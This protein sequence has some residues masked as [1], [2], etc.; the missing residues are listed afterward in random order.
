[1]ILVIIKL[2]ALTFFIVVAFSQFSTDN[3]TPFAPHGF[4][5]VISGASIIF[6][7]FLGFDAV[8]TGAEEARNPRRD[9]PIAII[10]SLAVATIFYV[11]VAVGA[12]G[13]ATPTQLA[14]SEAPLSAALE[15]G[16]GISWAASFLSVGAIVA[17]TSVLLV[18]LYA[19]TRILFAMCRDGLLP[20]GLASVNPRYGTPAKLTLGLG[21]FIAL[22][23]ALIPLAEI[24]KLVNVG[25][26][27]AFIVVN[28]GVIILRRTRPEMPRPYKVPFSP[29]VPLIGTALAVYLM[30]DFGWATWVRFFAWLIVGLLIY[31]FYGYRNSRIRTPHGQYGILPAEPA[32]PLHRHN[33]PE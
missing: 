20:E 5:G 1:M 19:Q 22:F 9:L 29:V 4:D 12:I 2:L 7:A 23:A 33:N 26:L 6:F 8:A 25:T 15:E 10:G 21:A 28:V 17:L 14:E 11:L 24:V 30:T 18:L 13:I 27:F 16:A 32:D 3:F 31:G